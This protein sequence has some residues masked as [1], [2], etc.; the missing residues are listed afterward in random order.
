MK[1]IKHMNTTSADLKFRIDESQL[2]IPYLQ[3][4]SGYV[5]MSVFISSISFYYESSFSFVVVA[6]NLDF[7]QGTLFMIMS[8]IVAIVPL[9]VQLI[10]G[11]NPNGRDIAAKVRPNSKIDV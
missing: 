10:Y 5:T 2:S 7:N 11:I 1:A 9:F 8:L 4:S 6:G 3:R